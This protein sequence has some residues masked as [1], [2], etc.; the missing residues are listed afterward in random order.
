LRCGGRPWACEAFDEEV[1]AST[2]FVPEDPTV[3]TTVA[4]LLFGI[5]TVVMFLGD[6]VAEE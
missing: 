2:A 1:V 6:L 5:V 4:A 3:P